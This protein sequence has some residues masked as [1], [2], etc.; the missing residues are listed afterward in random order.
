M[1]LATTTKG[2]VTVKVWV[3]EHGEIIAEIFIN[4]DFWDH[5]EFDTLQE[6]L[7]FSND[8][9]AED[10]NK[11]RR[12]RDREAAREAEMVPYRAAVLTRVSFGRQIGPNRRGSI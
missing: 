2:P 5:R 6:A 7:D 10:R 11:C 4:G 8:P 1:H 12:Q 9:L 3:V